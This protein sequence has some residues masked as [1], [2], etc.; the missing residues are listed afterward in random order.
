MIRR[1]TVDDIPALLAVA[2]DSG[3]FHASEVDQLA[4][5]MGEH[6]DQGDA[7]TDV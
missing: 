1:S 5:M 4:Q 2:Q 6:F 3:L 7:A